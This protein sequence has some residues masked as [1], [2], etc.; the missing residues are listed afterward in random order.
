VCINHA[1]L[2]HGQEFIVGRTRLRFEKPAEVAHSK[3]VGRD[4]ATREWHSP[5]AK[6]ILP[7]IVE[8]TPK[9]S[10]VRT[11]LTTPETWLGKDTER[12]QHVLANDPFVSPRHARLYVDRDGRW[13]I[14]N[15][16]SINGVWLRIEQ[17]VLK[18]SCGF[19]L[20]EQQFMLR[21]PS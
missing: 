11:T 13:V 17:L 15:N 20:G 16:K 5:L 7:S 14:E 19:M 6:N 9:N 21:I 3:P 1:L 18:R 8:L 10:G 4:E 12:C 2:E